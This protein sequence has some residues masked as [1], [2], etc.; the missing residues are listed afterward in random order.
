MGKLVGVGNQRIRPMR[1]YVLEMTNEEKLANLRKKLAEI[2]DGTW[3][4]DV[5]RHQNIS[6]GYRLE[7]V[8]KRTNEIL[9]GLENVDP[10]L[11]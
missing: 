9:K 7:L 4:Q 8:D 11:P 6:E 2:Q 1:L 3:M 5:F 10:T